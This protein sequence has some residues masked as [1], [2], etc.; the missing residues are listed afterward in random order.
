MEPDVLV[1]TGDHSTPA[2]LAAH[3]WHPVPALLHARTCRPGGVERFTEA[4]CA[5]G[6]LGRLP[7]KHLMPLA[8]G[9]AGKLAKFGA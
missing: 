7:M 5:R 9:H 6:T 2:L 1:V 3:S 8:L 4:E